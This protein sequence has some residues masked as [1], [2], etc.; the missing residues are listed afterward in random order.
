M[1]RRVRWLAVFS[2]VAVALL[3]LGAG[4]AAPKPDV[5]DG[6][7]VWLSPDTVVENDWGEVAFTLEGDGFPPLMRVELSSPGL[8]NACRHGD[9]LH[10]PIVDFNGYFSRAEMGWR[11][12]AGTYLVIVSE[13]TSPFASFSALLTVLPPGTED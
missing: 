3:P 2:A 5:V 4:H 9:T 10:D 8:D 1:L 6:T 11:C 7:S 12:A 13:A